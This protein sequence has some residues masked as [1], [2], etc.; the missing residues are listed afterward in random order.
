MRNNIFSFISQYYHIIKLKSLNLLNAFHDIII[1]FE[2]NFAFYDN[3]IF[4]L[5]TIMKSE[6]IGIFRQVDNFNLNINKFIFLNFFIPF[7]AVSISDD[8]NENI[9]FE[10]I[11][12]KYYQRTIHQLFAL[13]PVIF[14]IRNLL[15]MNLNVESLEILNNKKGIYI[16]TMK[17]VN[18]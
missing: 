11:I 18:L 15:E 5:N 3:N 7:F 9:V 6:E 1:C 10:F 4:V 14:V 16:C 17:Y 2:I 12:W 8:S 13:L